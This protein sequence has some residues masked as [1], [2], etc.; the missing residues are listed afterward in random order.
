M[1]MLEKEIFYMLALLLT[2]STLDMFVY[3]RIRFLSAV[4]SKTTLFWEK[5]KKNK[6]W[7][8]LIINTLPIIVWL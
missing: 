2:M 5:L 8:F 7:I 4:K 6:I 3:S 1:S